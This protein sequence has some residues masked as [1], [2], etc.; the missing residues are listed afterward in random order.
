M[1]TL[2][3]PPLLRAV[4]ASWLCVFAAGTCAA[5]Q[6]TRM[7]VITGVSGD[8]EHAKAFGSWATTLMDAAKTH[9]GVPDA[10]ITY[11][12]EKPAQATGRS[13]KEN[14]EKAVDRI[15]AAATPNDTVVIVLIGHGSFDG[16]T[17]AFNLPGPDL[18]V[19]DWARL[20]G[21]LAASHVVFV[22]TSSASGAFLP[23]VAAP[24]RTVITATKTGGEKNETRFAEF[25]VEAFSAPSADLDRNGRVSILEAF[26]YANAKVVT[27][28]E[29]G[30]FLRSEHATLEDGA[31]GTLAASLFLGSG[32]S[33]AGR[34]DLSDP[35]IRA[36]VGERDA[37]ERQIAAL[38][39]TKETMP[40][41]RYEAELERLL[42]ELAVKTRALRAM[43]VAK[44]VPQ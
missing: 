11:L 16:R 26:N 10:N 36:L 9:D 44:G 35:A 33:A 12:S 14:V 20:L 27:A 43:Q 29:Q 18:T 25:F 22:N 19:A 42:T 7:L 3:V 1:M 40:A 23:E 38:K 30:G 28:Y 5:A 21:R 4:V 8:E 15:A 34:Y 24:G 41:D 37:I 17:A 32:G 39:L 31:A 6:E 13:T 2:R